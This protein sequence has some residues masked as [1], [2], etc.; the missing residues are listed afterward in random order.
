MESR[1]WPQEASKEQWMNTDQR[2]TPTDVVPLQPQQLAAAAE[3]LAR[4][5][6]D[7]AVPVYAFPDPAKRPAMLRV[8]FSLMLR[9]G[10]R[11]GVVE[12]T[13]GPSGIA[14]WL[15]HERAEMTL[16]NSIPVGGLGFALRVGPGAVNRLATTDASFTRFRNTL[17]PFPHD[18]VA[19]VGVSPEPQC[20]GIGATLV[21]H[22]M[23]R[24]R[25]QNWACYLETQ[26]ERNVPLYLRLGFELKQDSNLPGTNIRNWCM[27][28][29]P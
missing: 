16:G 18:Y 9:Y 5:F 4:A 20:K 22:G 28:W 25:A 8:L 23:E 19:T 17:A 13:P 24:L 29:R 2:P 21:W 15:P 27:L 14:V 6:Y 12:V 7:A 10:M 1:T 26:N 3:V 11:H